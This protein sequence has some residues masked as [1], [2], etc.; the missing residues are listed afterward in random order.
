MAN[1]RIPLPGSGIYIHKRAACGLIER[2]EGYP[3]PS[4]VDSRLPISAIGLAGGESP[5]RLSEFS[6]QLI[7][8]EELPIIKL[9]SIAEEQAFEVVAPAKP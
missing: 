9:G 8:L 4:G 6:P 7:S 5:K 1:R 3:A 2:I